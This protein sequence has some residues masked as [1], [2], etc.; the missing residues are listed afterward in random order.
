VNCLKTRVEEFTRFDHSRILVR[1]RRPSI[2]D[3]AA[4]CAALERGRTWTDFTRKMSPK[5][6]LEDA[7]GFVPCT[8]LGVQR[9]ASESDIEVNG[10][11]V[12]VSPQHDRWQPLALLLIAEKTKTATRR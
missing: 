7:S 2:I 6:V 1:R 8:P 4:S 5:L 12:V 11:H 3:E 9:F 10:A